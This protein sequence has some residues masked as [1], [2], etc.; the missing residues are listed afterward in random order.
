M[1]LEEQGTVLAK[2]MHHL[3]QSVKMNKKAQEEMVGFVLIMLVVAVIL[4][5]FLGIYLSGNKQESTESAE[6]AQFLGAAFEYTTDC[7]RD[8]GYNPYRINDLI[9]ECGSNEG[10]L[11]QGSSRNVCQALGDNLKNLIESSWNFQANSPQTG[12]ELSITRE[13]ITGRSRKKI[14]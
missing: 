9:K 14:G 1:V 12:Y 5:V 2:F 6:I 8:A 3:N 10:K 11:C 7:N 13:T 4:L